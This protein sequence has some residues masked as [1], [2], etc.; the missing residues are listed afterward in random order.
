MQ[1]DPD[2]SYELKKKSVCEVTWVQ[3]KPTHNNREKHIKK[4]LITCIFK[5]DFWF[6]YENHKILTSLGQDPYKECVIHELILIK[7]NFLLAFS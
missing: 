2:T 5:T 4:R 7:I 1:A 6:L 3:P